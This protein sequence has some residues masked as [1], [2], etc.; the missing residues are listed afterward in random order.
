MP[1]ACPSGC[2]SAGSRNAI[3]RVY[4]VLATQVRSS[5]QRGY[6]LDPRRSSSL[7]FPRVAPLSPR[8]QTPDET[9]AAEP[10]ESARAPCRSPPGRTGQRSSGRSTRS[11]GD[12]ALARGARHRGPAPRPR[13]RDGTPPGPSGR[14][15]WLG[16]SVSASTVRAELVTALATLTGG[17]LR[18]GEGPPRSPGGR[19][20]VSPRSW[21]SRPS[22]R[23]PVAWAR[24]SANRRRTY[25]PG[26]TRQW[27]RKR[28]NSTVNRYPEGDWIVQV[29]R[30]GSLRATIHT[31]I[32]LQRCDYPLAEP[33]ES[34]QRAGLDSSTPAPHRSLPPPGYAVE[35]SA[36]TKGS[37]GG[38]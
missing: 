13:S 20:S 1:A 2:G 5:N 24:A 27:L 8:T 12:R 25:S 38:V 36:G 10:A 37:A 6:A 11:R 29:G 30:K 7:A 21:R 26:V 28:S 34:R 17:G 15:V 14:A 3:G 9:R 23:R 33:P 32:S 22:G 31:T 16:G 4:V 19:R 18:L 35:A